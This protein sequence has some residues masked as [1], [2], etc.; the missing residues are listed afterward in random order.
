MSRGLCHYL[1]PA[2]IVTL[3][4]FA[5]TLDLI[6][7]RTMLV[8]LGMKVSVFI[9]GKHRLMYILVSMEYTVY[10]ICT[11]RC[12]TKFQRKMLKSIPA[13]R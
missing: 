5:L 11:L 8:R 10:T 3:S 9:F 7:V 13:R 6:C 2:H 1:G 4:R 12:K